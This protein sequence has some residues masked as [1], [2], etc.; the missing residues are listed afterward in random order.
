MINCDL[1]LASVPPVADTAVEKGS[2]LCFCTIRALSRAS[3]LRRSSCANEPSRSGSQL[4]SPETFKLKGG[5]VFGS[6]SLK[7]YGC[8]EDDTPPR[9]KT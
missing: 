2:V 3:S 1:N 7:E 8:G 5:H 9:R 4:E 6:T